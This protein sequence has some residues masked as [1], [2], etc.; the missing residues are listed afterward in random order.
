M[1]HA[2]ATT[3]AA[4]LL[5]ASTASAYCGPT[6]QMLR[7][8]Q[9]FA[10]APFYGDRRWGSALDFPSQTLGWPGAVEDFYYGSVISEQA[11]TIRQ[12]RH[13]L[14]EQRHRERVA[15]IAE[16][17]NAITRELHRAAEALPGPTEAAETDDGALALTTALNGAAVDDV[18]V[19]FDAD[20]NVLRVSTTS[21]GG[22]VRRAWQL[23]ERFAVGEVAVEH[24]ADA[25]VLKILV[26]ARPEAAAD[27]QEDRGAAAQGAEGSVAQAA[28]EDRSPPASAPSS[29]PAAKAKPI[30]PTDTLLEEAA[31]GAA[32]AGEDEPDVPENVEDI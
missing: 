18:E 12:L 10:P 9:Y 27:R 5:F 28:A 1:P 19:E 14:R 15:A 32:G 8:Q 4:A 2:L 24:D 31:D 29:S 25:N 20:L 26:P 6:C 13:L 3:S 22:R 23:P 17:S 21:P 7:S 16:R 11:R 30:S